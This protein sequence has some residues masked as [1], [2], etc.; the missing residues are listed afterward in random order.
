ML[1]NG[2]LSQLLEVLGSLLYFVIYFRIIQR[3]LYTLVLSILF[4]SLLSF[5]FPPPSFFFFES[6]VW[7]LFGATPSNVQR[8]FLALSLGII[9]GGLR[10]PSQLHAK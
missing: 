7:F 6:V 4:L 3:R 8:L 2:Y 9:L 1:R 5:F 10:V